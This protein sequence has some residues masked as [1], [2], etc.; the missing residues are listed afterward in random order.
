MQGGVGGKMRGCS[1][2]SARGRGLLGL[3]TSAGNL[4]ASSSSYRPSGVRGGRIRRAE[5]ARGSGLAT[6]A[7]KVKMEHDGETVEVEV[8]EDEYI[9]DAVENAGI[10]VPYDCRMGVCMQC[11]ARLVSGEVDQSEGMISDDVAEKGFVLMCVAKC[12]SD[13][14]IETVTEVRT[15][16][17]KPTHPLFP[18]HPVADTATPTHPTPF[19]FVPF[20]L[21]LPLFSLRTSSWT[22][23]W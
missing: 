3:A 7:F 12:Q 20:P 2:R 6:L 23:S 4:D 22:S 5:A 21:S 16:Q 14:S 9:L 17:A 11:P 10:E 1:L 8:D 15:S 13:V 18:L 19:F